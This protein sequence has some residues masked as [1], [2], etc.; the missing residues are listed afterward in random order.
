MMNVTV[1]V[2]LTRMLTQIGARILILAQ[3][4][5]TCN[6]PVDATTLAVRATKTR[7]TLLGALLSPVRGA[8]G[9]QL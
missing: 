8:R 9:A 1:T 4:R 7:L 5:R 2:T 6:L 3:T